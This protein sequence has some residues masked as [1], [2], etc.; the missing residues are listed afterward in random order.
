MTVRRT[1]PQRQRSLIGAWCF[2]DHYG[3][4][5]VAD[6]GGMDVAAAPAHRA[7]DGELAVHRRDRAPRQPRGPRDGPARRAEP[8]DRRPRHRHSEVSTPRTTDP[9]RRPAVGGA[10]R[11]APA[12]PRGLPAPRARAG[13]DRRRH[14]AGL[15]RHAGRRDLSGAPL[16]PRCSARSSSSSPRAELTLDVDPAFEHGVLVDI[17]PVMLD[18]T[19]L[20]PR[21]A[22]LPRP[23]PDRLTL[24]NRADEPARVL[25]LG[26]APFERADRHVVELRRP[27]P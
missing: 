27:H 25:L 16:T 26:G 23:G 17:G 19:E 22:R 4:D 5:D 13:R 9:A 20:A 2:A 14:G 21:R 11:P 24:A 10:A 12:T 8:D 1:L 6:T 3:P 15:P 7:A 18:G